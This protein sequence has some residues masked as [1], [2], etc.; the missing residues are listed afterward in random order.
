MV[1][2]SCL[3]EFHC[4]LASR[5]KIYKESY[6]LRTHAISLYRIKAMRR[7]IKQQ[8]LALPIKPF[9]F[10]AYAFI[11]N[12]SQNSCN[13]IVCVRVFLKM[14]VKLVTN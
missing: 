10:G 5:K 11:D 3:I 1:D 13:V 9:G 14:T 4:V 6:N 12:L 7:S 8:Y 2:Y